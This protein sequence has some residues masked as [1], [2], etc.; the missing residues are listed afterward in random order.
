VV[1]VAGVIVAVGRAF[2]VITVAELVEAGQVPP[3]PSEAFVMITV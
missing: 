3:E 1:V 2:T